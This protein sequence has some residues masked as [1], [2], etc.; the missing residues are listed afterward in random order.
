MTFRLALALAL[1]LLVHFLPFLGEFNRSRRQPPAP[2][3]PI[4]AE[5]RRPAPPLPPPPPLA[6]ER[7]EP[8]RPTVPPPVL[9]RATRPAAAPLPAP[10]A[11]GW[12][13]EVRRQFRKQQQA[14]RFYPA[15]AIA[16]GLEGEVVVLMILNESG[17]VSAA[18]V[19]QGSGQRLLDEAALQAVRALHSLPADAPRETL[20]PVRFR[21]H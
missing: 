20:L 11:P 16:L 7:P 15:E 5:I 8:S 18:R 12:E 2:P 13:H 10:A 21:L 1:S 17:Q 9:T 3:P 19:E 4:R 14:G 6:I